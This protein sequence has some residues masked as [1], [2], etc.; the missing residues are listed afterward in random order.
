[1]CSNFLFPDNNLFNPISL[2]RSLGTIVSFGNGITFWKEK[3][4]RRKAE[5]F[6]RVLEWWECR[7]QR[8]SRSSQKK[9]I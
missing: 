9:L 1:M 5:L 4:K 8:K 7:F 2:L 3:A 6:R